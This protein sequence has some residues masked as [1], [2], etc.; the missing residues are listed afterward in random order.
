MS[1]RPDPGA[2]RDRS[3]VVTGGEGFLGRVLVAELARLGADVRP[4]RHA[5]HDLRTPADARAALDGADV[6]FHLAARVGGIGF[7]LRHP[8]VLAHDNLLLAAH[9]FE[10]AH[11]VGVARLVAVSSVCAYPAAPPLPF[12]EDDL[13]N[14]YPEAS[15]APYGIAKRALLM[16]SDAYWRQYGLCSCTPVL[17]NLYGPGDHDDPEDSH[18][19]PALVRRFTEARTRGEDRVAAWGTGRATR[20]LLFVDDAVRALLLAAEIVHEPLALNVG[21]GREWSIAE[22]AEIVAR[23]VG[24]EGEIAWDDERPDGQAQ[25]RLD[26][27]RAHEV[28]GWEAEVGLEE[29]L[30]RTV[31]GSAARP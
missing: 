23:L 20:D 2:W 14:G 24:Y 10:Q 17:T 28:L 21:T 13:W 25:R 30:R 5:E 29:G 31:T 16:L 6:V 27:S 1:A 12:S 4:V 8:A 18:V 19:V 3:V 7:N 9:V 11:R 15:N 26:V 22:V